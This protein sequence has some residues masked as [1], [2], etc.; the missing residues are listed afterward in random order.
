MCGIRR[1]MESQ[2]SQFAAGVSSIIDGGKT[3]SYLRQMGYFT[4]FLNTSTNCFSCHIFSGRLCH[5]RNLK[6]H[7]VIATQWRRQAGV[8]EVLFSNA[9]Y[10]SIFQTPPTSF[11]TEFAPLH[12]RS[13]FKLNL[14][15]CDVLLIDGWATPIRKV[16]IRVA[17]IPNIKFYSLI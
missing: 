1:K 4:A 15:K 14:M 8:S 6:F 7:S 5:S 2:I 13:E 12:N 16:R 9:V 11:S 3:R 17:V 10:F